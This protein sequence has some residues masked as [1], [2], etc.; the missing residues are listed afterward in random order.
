M[1]TGS[2]PSH[3]GFDTW[4]TLATDEIAEYN[5]FYGYTNAKIYHDSNINKWK[6]ESLYN[7]S[8][9]ATCDFK[10]YPIGV[11]TWKPFGGSSENITL[12]L[13]GCSDSSEANCDDGSCIDIR[14]R[15]GK[16]NLN[17]QALGAKHFFNFR[18]NQVDD[19]IDG[20]DEEDCEMIQVPPSYRSAA[21]PYQNREFKISVGIYIYKVL[22]LSEV[23]SIMAV[24]FRLELNWTDPRLQFLNLKDDRTSNRVTHNKG[25]RI[26]HPHLILLNTEK[27]EETKVKHL[28]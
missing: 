28:H 1:F 26:W 23:N 4:F 12:N 21:P 25:E 24:Q 18:C 15:L 5:T 6:M 8:E 19:C 13:N 14:K 11:K 20:S 2:I 22:E 27:R 3:F 9:F 7:K 16:A 17:L 10:D